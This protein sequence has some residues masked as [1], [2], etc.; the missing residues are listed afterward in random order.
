[1]LPVQ[2]VL[3]SL[4]SEKLQSP[5]NNRTD[6]MLHILLSSS[7]WGSGVMFLFHR[8]YMLILCLPLFFLQHQD[9]Q[10][11]NGSK[12]NSFEYKSGIDNGRSGSSSDRESQ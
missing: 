8:L 10:V 9:S 4:S 7:G 6:F 11:S 3:S 2:C 1:M 5:S 12:F